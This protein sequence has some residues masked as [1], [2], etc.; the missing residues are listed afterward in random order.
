MALTTLDKPI[1]VVSESAEATLEL[2]RAVGALLGSGEVVGLFGELGAGKTTFIKGCALGLGVPDARVVT[3]PTFT[4]MNIYHGRCPVYHFDLY[5]IH[6]PGELAELGHADFF[7]GEG[8]SL[9]EWAERAGPLLPAR[10]LRV[11]CTTLGPDRR[12]IEV[13]RGGEEQA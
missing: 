6:S 5:R 1:R 8:V 13:T 9:V 2:G 12:R 10:A 4:L 3:S 11:V 7:G